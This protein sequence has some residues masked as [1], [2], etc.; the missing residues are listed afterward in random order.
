MH[1]VRTRPFNLARDLDAFFLAAGRG[2]N[3]PAG[4]WMPRVDI[5]EVDGTLNIRYEL[6]GFSADDL[7]VTL[8]DG[9]LK[10]SG[11]RSFDMPEGAEFH[12]KELSRGKFSRTLRVTDAYDAERVNASFADGLLDVTLQKRP[13]V[14]PKTI[15]IEAR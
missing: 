6:A 5:Y 10:V 1:M 13:E 2:A 8:E 9:L 7:E 11:S 12:R 3:A 4:T 14:L 15:E